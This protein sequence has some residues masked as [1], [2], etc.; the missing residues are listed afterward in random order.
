MS[1]VKG[2]RL[3]KQVGTRLKAHMGQWETIETFGT[4]RVSLE[5]M[6]ES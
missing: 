5:D 6:D 4:E 2:M 1:Y 3:T